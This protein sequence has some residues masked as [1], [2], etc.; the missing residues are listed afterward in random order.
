MGILSAP[1]SPFLYVSN[2]EKAKYVTLSHR[3]G[4]GN[5]CRTLKAT[6]EQYTTG[7]PT[8]EISNVFR[9]A[10][11]V[12]RRLGIKFLWIDSLCII[13]DS[14]EDWEIES[15]KMA[16][17]YSNAS[18]TIAA[19][20]ASNVDTG[21]FSPYDP[22]LVRPCRVDVKSSGESTVE[23]IRIWRETDLLGL[24]LAYLYL[25]YSRAWVFQEQTLSPKILHFTPAGVLWECLGANYTESE[26]LR[27]REWKDAPLK[28]SLHS[29]REA[30]GSS[31]QAVMFDKWLHLVETYSGREMKFDT[32]WLPAISGIAKVML[33]QLQC[34]YNEYFA[35]LWRQD[36]LRCLSWYP[37]TARARGKKHSRTHPYVA[38]SWA[39]AALN[40]PISFPI[41]R[42]GYRFSFSLTSE[43]HWPASEDPKPSAV[44]LDVRSVVQGLDPTGKISSGKIVLF[45]PVC[46]NP[47]HC[48]LRNPSLET[49]S[50]LVW[51]RRDDPNNEILGET[52]TFA[53][54]IPQEMLAVDSIL[55]RL[56]PEFALIL[57]RNM[58]PGGNMLHRRV[59]WCTVDRGTAGTSTFITSDDFTRQEVVVIV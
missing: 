26:P 3:W 20:L 57:E 36:M 45:G 22:L 19:A 17:I 43:T 7:L 37:N 13:Q 58:C 46:D 25:L 55:L 10:I 29:P 31:N 54:D 24:N 59:G 35:G 51:V 5:I 9:D 2:G 30:A 50:D 8:D 23:I 14:V 44:V 27:Q 53:L 33:K 52:D 40:G 1:C 21:L 47:F 11:E 15:S 56:Y 42:D 41:R 4:L 34:D 38:P 18:F 32:D 28:L 16:E 49:R 6:I 12:T 48:L 39:W